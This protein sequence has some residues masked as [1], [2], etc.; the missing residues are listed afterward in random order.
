MA[1]KVSERLAAIDKYAEGIINEHHDVY[2]AIVDALMKKQILTREELLEIKNT[3][4]E[5]SA[6]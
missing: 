4:T 3:I 5:K 2:E 6:A 1:E